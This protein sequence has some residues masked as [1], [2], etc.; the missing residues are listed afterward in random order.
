MEIYISSVLSVTCLKLHHCYCTENQTPNILHLLLFWVAVGLPNLITGER[1]GQ[2][3]VTPNN[4]GLT[5]FLGKVFMCENN[6]AVCGENDN[7]GRFSEGFSQCVLQRQIKFVDQ[8]EFRL[9]KRNNRSKISCATESCQGPLYLR[10]QLF[11]FCCKNSPYSYI[12]TTGKVY[13]LRQNRTAC[14]G[15]KF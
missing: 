14:H 5:R 4:L 3:Q 9:I 15:F 6:L 10:E 11:P 8:V 7:S 12:T 2:A 1:C 13:F